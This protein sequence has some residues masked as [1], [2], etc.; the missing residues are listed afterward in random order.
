MIVWVKTHKTSGVKTLNVIKILTLWPFPGNGEGAS[1]SS[2]TTGRSW[3]CHCAGL[4]D[5][6]QYWYNSFI[7]RGRL[8]CGPIFMDIEVV[9]RKRGNDYQRI[10]EKKHDKYLKGF[11]D[12]S[13]DL[14]QPWEY[15]NHGPL[16]I[17][18]MELYSLQLIRQA[19]GE[20]WSS[21]VAIRWQSA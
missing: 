14:D 11:C 7:N 6:T 13:I 5:W 3:A 4:Y 19:A 8:L 1:N 2:G 17:T 16:R 20:I 15:K 18:L 12:H 9:D 10:A 21:I